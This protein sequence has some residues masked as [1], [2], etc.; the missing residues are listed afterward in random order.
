MIGPGS[1]SRMSLSE[2]TDALGRF[3]FDGLV[4]GSKCVL[5]VD[6]DEDS[7]GVG[8]VVTQEVGVAAG[9]TTLP[10][11]VVSPNL[12][13][14]SLRPSRLDAV[15]SPIQAPRP[16]P[17]TSPDGRPATVP[18][19]PSRSEISELIRTVNRDLVSAELI[20]RIAALLP[21]E[22]TLGASTSAG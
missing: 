6:S 14:E 19:G 20:D 10:D 5:H 2:F 21:P 3:R 4:V 22:K 12:D 7:D 15:V 17:P 9:A 11:I 13:P 1:V 18:S 16:L 8:G